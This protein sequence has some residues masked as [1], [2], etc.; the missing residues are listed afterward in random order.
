M[1][2]YGNRSPIGTRQEKLLQ[3]LMREIVRMTAQEQPLEV[4]VPLYP[5][6]HAGVFEKVP[7][8]GSSGGGC[9]T[10]PA[11]IP[12]SSPFGDLTGSP[13]SVDPS[14]VMPSTVHSGSSTMSVSSTGWGK[15][16]SVSPPLSEE[17]HH[18]MT[19]L[20]TYVM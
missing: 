9:P 15:D 6:S 3:G 11:P 8:S 20:S 19:G 10:P 12:H 17:Y 4:G 18:S 2:E 1:L 13:P 5:F 16:T 14:P 7:S